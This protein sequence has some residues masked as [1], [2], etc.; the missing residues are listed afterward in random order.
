MSPKEVLELHVTLTLKSQVVKS[1]DGLFTAG[2][3]D[4]VKRREDDIEIAG[5]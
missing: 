3:L 4:R 1:F 5:V 2:Q